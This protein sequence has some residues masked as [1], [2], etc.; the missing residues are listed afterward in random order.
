MWS[1][2][3]PGDAS[4]GRSTRDPSGRYGSAVSRWLKPLG[5]RAEFWSDVSLA[6]WS[7]VLAIAWLVSRDMSFLGLT[8]QLAAVGWTLRAVG[9]WRRLQLAEH[10]A[11]SRES[12]EA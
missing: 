12:T 5:P 3:L 9:S 6:V 11:A 7:L 4:A 10:T 8:F 2:I 1:L